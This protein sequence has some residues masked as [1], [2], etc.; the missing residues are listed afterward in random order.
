MEHE[1]NDGMSEWRSQLHNIYMHES[2]ELVTSTV[3]W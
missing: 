3:K 1:T 2:H